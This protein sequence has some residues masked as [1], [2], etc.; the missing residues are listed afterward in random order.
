MHTYGYFLVISCNFMLNGL[1]LARK[2][3]FG[4]DWFRIHGVI[5]QTIVA[6]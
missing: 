2:S 5:V 4:E 3:I 6:A 1:Q